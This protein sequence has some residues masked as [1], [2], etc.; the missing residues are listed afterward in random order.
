MQYCLDFVFP[1]PSACFGTPV[2][3]YAKFGECSFKIRNAVETEVNWR[4]A[5]RH[6]YRV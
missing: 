4:E 3:R 2:R 6:P 1:I 5:L